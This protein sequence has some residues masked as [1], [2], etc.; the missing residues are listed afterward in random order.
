MNAVF[1]T[2]EIPQ[3]Q[4]RSRALR[5]GSSPPKSGRRNLALPQGN[6]NKY[7][8]WLLK[9]R[10]QMHGTLARQGTRIHG[11]AMIK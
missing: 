6:N 9:G 10:A 7:P 1:K 8:H 2:W 4:N 5:R 11:N 3:N